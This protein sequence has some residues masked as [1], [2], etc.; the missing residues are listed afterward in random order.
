MSKHL[1][2]MCTSE[3]NGVPDK[4]K[5]LPFGNVKSQ[6]GD[7]I[8][9]DE[10][11]KQMKERFKSRGLD[12]V[13]D[14]EHQTLENTQAPAGGWIKDIEKE[15]NAIV[16]KVEW[17]PKA[18][19]YLKNKEYRYLSPV[20]LV[21][22]KDNKAV[23]LHSVAL[24]NTP[25]I[26]NM[27]PI[28]NSID[29][30]QYEDNKED[31]KMDLKEIAKQ[32]GLPEDATEEQIKEALSKVAEVIQKMKA[33]KEAE[34][35]KSKEPEEPKKEEGTE[36]VANKT[37]LGAL[38]LDET[39]K[40]EDVAA[41]IMSLKNSAEDVKALKEKIQKDESKSLVIKALKDGKITTAQQEWAEEYAL[42]DPEGF[43]AFTEKAPRTVP[44]GK[45]NYSKEN[46]KKDLEDDTTMQVLKQL[47]VSKED[48]EKNVEVE[49]K[50]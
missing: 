29:L 31:E 39:A 24:T 45:I 33:N 23:V 22:K 41:L 43:K 5:I 14:Y 28:I 47:G 18:Q 17:T 11:F 26:D 13:I 35:G 4:I 32:L 38:G 12:L 19:E 15:D 49:C 46:I 44:V 2:F 10:S 3:V 48:V 34:D 25:A 36:V 30:N 27:Y 1:I 21:R 6:K 16:A 37:I 50:W 8:V 7:F 20:V 40:T 9:D 42:K